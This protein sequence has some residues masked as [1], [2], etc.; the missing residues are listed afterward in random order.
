M[1]MIKTDNQGNSRLGDGD[2][3]LVM[4][5]LRVDNDIVECGTSMSLALGYLSIPDTCL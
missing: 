1:F 5:C 4:C 2:R 3:C